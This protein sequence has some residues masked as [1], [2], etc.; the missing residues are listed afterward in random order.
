MRLR[1]LIDEFAFEGRVYR[2]PQG[3]AAIDYLVGVGG[4]EV[5]RGRS[6]EL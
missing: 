6:R 5:A 3:V 1:K 2:F 4:G